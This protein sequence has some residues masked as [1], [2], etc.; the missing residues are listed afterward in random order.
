M[1]LT[2]AVSSAGV[3]RS[4]SVYKEIHTAKRNKLLQ[5][6]LNDLMLIHILGPKWEDYVPG[7]DYIYWMMKY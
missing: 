6:R 1:F 2:I 3:E 7:N 4:F 5:N